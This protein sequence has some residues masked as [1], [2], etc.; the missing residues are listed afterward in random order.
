MLSP[1][2]SLFLRRHDPIQVHGFGL[3]ISVPAFVRLQHTPEQGDYT[4]RPLETAA[5]TTAG[6]LANGVGKH[7]ETCGNEEG[8]NLSLGLLENLE[9][10]TSLELATST[11]ARLRSTN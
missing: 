5:F 6:R 7:V 2:Q 9:R 11:L 1:R 10:E 8:P 4:L 3:V